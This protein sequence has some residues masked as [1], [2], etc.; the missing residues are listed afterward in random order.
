M[1]EVIWNSKPETDQMSTN[2]KNSS[3][4][5]QE[6]WIFV[7]KQLWR[8][9]SFLLSW[10]SPEAFFPFFIFH[11]YSSMYV[12]LINEYT[13]TT[14]V[15]FKISWTLLFIIGA[16]LLLDKCT[17]LF[18]TEIEGM[19]A[20]YQI[21]FNFSSWKNINFWILQSIPILEYYFNSFSFLWFSCNS[22]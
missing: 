4:H 10:N 18:T 13:M 14:R 5:W 2:R 12:N 16:F 21:S 7:L 6:I 15:N 1:I 19:G 9:E 17:F 20:I 11:K 3:F 22:N 8:W